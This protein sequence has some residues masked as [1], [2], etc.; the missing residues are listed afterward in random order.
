MDHNPEIRQRLFEEFSQVVMTRGW[1]SVS[2]AEIATKADIDIKLAF[3]EYRD[4]YAYVSDLVRRIDQ[5]MLESYDPDM[6]DEP[7]RERL[8]DVIMARFDAMQGHRDL[9]LEL[10]KAA[11]RDPMLG[12][13]LLALSRLTGEWFLDI[14]HISPAG[15]SGMARSKGALLAYARAFSVWIGDDSADLAK[16]MAT[17]DKFLKKGEKALHRAEKIACALPRMGK[18]CRKSRRRSRS[19]A[20]DDAV[21]DDPI[22]SE[23]PSVDGGSM[24]P[25]PS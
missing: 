7:A 24:A 13:H 17:L 23:G 9:I 1:R 11:R 16:T 21:K 18:R 4:R 20:G 14:S 3:L 22:V 15:L 25:M 5:A 12:L 2:C 10:N 8:F 19:G 6:G